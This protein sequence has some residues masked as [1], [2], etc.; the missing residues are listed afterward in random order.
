MPMRNSLR[1]TAAL[2]V[3]RGVLPLGVLLLT[4]QRTATDP[5]WHAFWMA[6]EGLD[7]LAG[8][9]FVHPDHWSWAPMTNDFAPTSP[10]WQVLL[11]GAWLVGG[12]WGLALFSFLALGACL[13]ALAYV[14]RELGA[15]DT[16]VLI[17]L[18][19]VSYTASQL[20]VPRAALPALCLLVLD[21]FWVW[22][23]RS[24]IAGMPPRRAVI[25]GA[26]GSLVIAFVG[27]WIHGSWT[28]YCMVVAAAAM[29]LFWRVPNVSARRRVACG[30][31]VAAG[32]VLGTVTGPLGPTAWRQAALVAENCRGLV[33]EWMTPAQ[34]GGD[35]VT[36]WVIS[37]IVLAAITVEVFRDPRS[38]LAD[39]RVV[40]LALAW[41]FL[42]AGLLAV[43]FILISMVFIGL[44]FATHVRHPFP[45]LTLARDLLRRRYSPAFGRAVAAGVL[46]ALL[47]VAAAP[48]P[49][50]FRVLESNSIAE[51]PAHCRVFSADTLAGVVVLRRPDVTT[52]IDGRLDYWGRER[53]IAARDYFE[54]RNA[55]QL[56]PPGTQCIL[57]QSAGRSEQLVNAINQSGD[58]R[59]VASDP[60]A[61]L[62]VLRD[63]DVGTTT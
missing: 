33:L 63:P 34:L 60:E 7:I 12:R 25:T 5:G 27:I 56:V 9:P 35:W 47:P 23:Y 44:L 53:L 45:L 49:K 32:S 14:G 42:G 62:W 10:A 17:T 24:D 55:R 37:C 18:A 4:V 19:I 40:L 1:R 22:K 59:R 41:V 20:F 8:G 48:I 46:V 50:T 58:W 3:N 61:E 38:E 6:R 15:S 31:A 2:L 29:Y 52:W 30:V 36:I 54:L 43:R 21:L 26:S 28:A 13:T 11:G 39:L 57:L 16:N 51:I